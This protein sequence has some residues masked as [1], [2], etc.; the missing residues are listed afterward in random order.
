M[1]GLGLIHIETHINFAAG[2]FHCTS[3]LYST[4]NI[5]AKWRARNGKYLLRRGSLHV[6]AITLTQI[7]VPTSKVVADWNDILLVYGRRKTEVIWSDTK[8]A[9]FSQKHSPLNKFDKDECFILSLKMRDLSKLVATQFVAKIPN[10]PYH[11]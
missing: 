5:D 3:M 9:K 6:C 11:Y 7:F 8:F 4:V 2:V 10:Q 1:F